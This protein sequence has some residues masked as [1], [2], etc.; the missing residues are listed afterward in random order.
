LVLRQQRNSAVELTHLPAERVA[1]RV[2]VVAKHADQVGDAGAPA[3]EGPAE[4]FGVG[5]AHH[6]RFGA[7]KDGNALEAL[8]MQLLY[9]QKKKIRRQLP[10]GFEVTKYMGVLLMTLAGESY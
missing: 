9:V 6:A 8:R 3:A 1:G 7:V 5:G 4:C 10:L 2:C